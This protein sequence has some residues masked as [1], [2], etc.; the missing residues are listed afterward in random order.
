MYLVYLIYLSYSSQSLV[1]KLKGKKKESL[2]MK[3]V[4]KE[5][6]KQNNVK[7]FT[8]LVPLSSRTKEEIQELL[9][10]D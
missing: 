2:I 4:R 8:A 3:S 5:N 7:N 9:V 10:K 6:K 1:E